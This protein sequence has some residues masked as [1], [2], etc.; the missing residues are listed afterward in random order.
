MIRK[1]IFWCL[2]NF[3]VLLS[4]SMLLFAF[5]TVYDFYVTDPERFWISL[6]SFQSK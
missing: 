3:G 2:R 5:W 4:F 6:C 1:I